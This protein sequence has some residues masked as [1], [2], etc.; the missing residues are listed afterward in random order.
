[1]LPQQL[2]LPKLEALA[3]QVVPL[4]PPTT[5][6]PR[7]LEVPEVMVAQVVPPTPVG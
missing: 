5:H 6:Q 1:M 3:E 7:P 2:V 4:R